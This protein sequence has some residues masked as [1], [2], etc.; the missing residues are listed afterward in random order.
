MTAELRFGVYLGPVIVI[1]MAPCAAFTFLMLI[2]FVHMF[3]L[4]YYLGMTILAKHALE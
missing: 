4:L 1:V 3:V 2:P